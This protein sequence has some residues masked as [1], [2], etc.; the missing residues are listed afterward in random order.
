MD[1]TIVVALIAVFP[2]SVLAGAALITSLRNGKKVDAVHVDVN[3]RLTELLETTR[4]A[5]RAE[6]VLEGRGGPPK[7]GEVVGEVDGA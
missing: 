6:G 2:P 1:N 4:V 3:S 7:Q 5:S